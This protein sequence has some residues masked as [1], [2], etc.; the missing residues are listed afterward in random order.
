M[1]VFFPCLRHTITKL[2]FFH[3]FQNERDAIQ[4]TRPDLLFLNHNMFQF[5]AFGWNILLLEVSG[6][7]S[8]AMLC[9]LLMS[10]FM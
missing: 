2:I 7:W 9:I 5:I 6:K 3:S 1:W 10:I 8:L 4:A